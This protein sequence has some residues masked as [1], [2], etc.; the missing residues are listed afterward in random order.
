[1]PGADGLALLRAVRDDYPDLP[2]ALVTGAPDIES[3][4]LAVDLGAFRYLRKPLD[5]DAL[6]AL[7]GDGVRLHTVRRSH[8]HAAQ[9]HGDARAEAD[10]ALDE[11]LEGLWMAYQPIVSVGGTPFAYEALLRTT[12]QVLPTPDA[13]LS[14]AESVG[15]V[16]DVGR[17][18]RR[19]VAREMCSSNATVFVNIHPVELLDDD[20]IG[21]ESPLTPHAQRIVLEIT[22]RASIG[23]IPELRDRVARLRRAGYRIALDDL[24]AGYASL[25]CFS[26]IE[27]DFAKIDQTLVRGVHRDRT[28]ARLIS[29]LLEMCSDLGVVVIAEGVETSEEHA[30]LVD[31][32]CE[33]LQGY[34]FGR[35]VAGLPI[36]PARWGAVQ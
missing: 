16:A 22:E 32:G 7:A 23:D 14:A 3:A 30:A 19:R 4:I 6:E 2:V 8:R 24:G 28:K 33:V 12:N 15:R 25:G 5:V 34:R 13:V 20:L 18:V 10:V 27:L 35:P 31:L 17:R 29:G 11:A 26:Q 1:M 36:G 9:P 21:G